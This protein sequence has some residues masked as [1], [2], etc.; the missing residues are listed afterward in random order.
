VFEDR[1]GCTDWDGDGWSNAGDALPNDASQWADSDG[2]GY[3]DNA[4]GNFADEFPSD[5]NQW[6]DTDGDGYGDAPVGPYGDWWPNDP[7]QWQDY[8]G[9]G[10]GDNTNGTNGDVCPTEHGTSTHEATRGCP[11]TD[12]DGV[13]DL[14]DPFPDDFYQWA[15]YDG[16][17]WGDNGAVP[18]GDECPEVF[19]TSKNGNVHGCPDADFDGWWDVDDIFPNDATQWEDSDGDGYGDNY[20]WFN[21]SVSDPENAGVVITL[22]AENGDAFPSESSQWNDT[23]GDGRG[24]NPNGILPDAFPLRVS[25]S[26]DLDK[27]GYGD[28][29][30]LGAYQP[31][32]CPKIWGNSITITIGPLISIQWENIYSYSVSKY[33]SNTFTIFK[34]TK[35]GSPRFIEI[36]V[37]ITITIGIL[38]L[39]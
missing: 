36:I 5:P 2:D 37:S 34:T 6:K 30:T 25:Q 33:Y 11:D 17:G 19:G 38:M 22:R 32:D 31:D 1:D 28:N 26:T 39:S 8:D 14:Q 15:D 7:S 16:D 29:F 18:N 35:H 9:D 20:S 12:H 23:D 3:G 10:Y 4:S 13:V 21:D 27:D 24:D